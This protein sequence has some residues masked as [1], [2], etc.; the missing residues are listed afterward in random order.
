M[1][2]IETGPLP[3]PVRIELHRPAA[4]QRNATEFALRW[5]RPAEERDLARVR[6]DIDKIN[7]TKAWRN[8][9][10]LQ[11]AM[12]VPPFEPPVAALLARPEESFVAVQPAGNVLA[13]IDPR[14]VA[15]G[16]ERCGPACRRVGFEQQQLPLIA[17][18]DGDGERALFLPTHRGEIGVTLAVPLNP[19]RVG[20]TYRRDPE[21]HLDI[22]LPGAGITGRVGRFVRP[23]GVGN[24]PDLDPGG[25][26]FLVSNETRVRRPPITGETI[27]LLPRHKFGQSM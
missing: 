25:V 21:A 14:R 10:L 26:G 16:E 20:A 4:V 7:E 19:D 17:R 22:G 24:I 9:D 2:L 27:H 3:A 23:G 11:S 15:L 18:L 8:K 1:V 13:Q 5:V 12:P 6:I